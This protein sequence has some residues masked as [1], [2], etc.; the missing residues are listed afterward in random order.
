MCDLKF[1]RQSKRVIAVFSAAALAVASVPG[2]AKAGKT[3]TA[4]EIQLTAPYTT[5][6]K[7]VSSTLTLKKGQS[8]K[9]KATVFPSKA[10]KSTKLTYKSSKKKIASVNKKGRILA[11]KPG[12]ATITI[13][14]K[15]NNKIKATIQVTVIK[16]VKKV[17]KISLNKTT[18]S[19]NLRSGK[20]SE[21]L[22]AKVISPKNATVKKFNWYSTDQS[23]ASVNSKGVVTAKKV[24]TTKIFATS[25]DGRGAKAS[26]LVS[27]YD[28]AVDT[29]PTPNSSNRPSAPPSVTASAAPS[30]TPT[31]PTP[32]PS[33]DPSNSPSS[34]PS[35][36]LSIVIPGNNRT[37]IKQGEKLALTTAGTYEGDISWSVTERAGVSI[38]A[39]GLLSIASDATIGAKITVTAVAAT[40]NSINDTAS[41]T[42]VENQTPVL[43]DKQTQLNESTETNPFG[44]TYRSPDAYSTVSD[45]ERGDVI[46]FDSSQGYT[47]SS[48]DVLAWM[49]VDPKYAG[50]TVKISAYLKYESNPDI[51][52]KLN[53]V[54]N[55]RW[56]YS[57]PAV[58]WNAEP[59]T[60]YYITGTYTFPANTSGKYN[61]SNNRLYICRDSDLTGNINAVYYIDDL[62]FY[63]DKPA[64]SGVTVNAQGNAKI[65]YQNSTLQFTSK[66][67]GAG[68]PPQG[69]T[70]SIDPAVEGASISESGLLSVGDVDADTTIT[71][72][73][74]SVENPDVSGTATVTVAA[75][76]IDS[77][78]ISAAGNVTDIYQ[79]STLQLRANVSSTG[80]PNTSVTWSIEPTVEGASI[81]S[82]GLLTVG[83]V[84]ADTQIHV[85]A[86]SVYDQSKSAEYT[87]TVQASTVDNVTITSAGNKTTVSSGLPLQLSAKVEVTG[88]PSKDVTWSIPSPVEG[89]SLASETGDTN[90]LTVTDSV[91]AETTIT[92]R[93]TSD[94]DSGKYGEITVTVTKDTEEEFNINKL[95]VEYFEDFDGAGTTLD[96][97]KEGDVFSWKATDTSGLMSGNLTK[98]DK[99]YGL[100][101]AE[102]GSP[103]YAFSSIFGSEEDYVQFKINNTDTS[104]KT[105]TLSFMFRFHDID[106]DTKYISTQM[107]TNP[108]FISYKLPLKLVSVDDAENPTTIKENIEI[109]F[110]CSRYSDGNME[111]YDIS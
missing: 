77:I 46:R 41:F 53:L 28:K 13:K 10:K 83:N 14:A 2:Q 61:G 26:C 89:A 57:N 48:Y 87:L 1:L 107:K 66:V 65:I 81:N 29:T 51:K 20:T 60:W 110:R 12:K 62:M 108:S 17:K 25:A 43:T 76:T 45:P 37:G 85:K 100:L 21:Q 96:S 92:V 27:V 18:L 78:S 106:A 35:A 94:Y 15:K 19:I 33:A 22:T 102:G 36:P 16:S 93:A 95:D 11:R 47:S 79:N 34:N 67:E 6:A 56:G 63:V 5:K 55:E 42:I 40:D 54:I 64:V 59:D 31:Q 30:N 111:Y 68:N 101:D 52:K 8:F 104:E 70:Y 84:T 73:A 71:V 49:D 109:P 44:L 103:T 39:D 90:T 7:K 74:T 24:G 9:I 72:K 88:T 3:T 4:K 69:V 32:S 98:L 50:K 80:N 58:K 99:G 91:A 38:S 75:R 82:T 105:Y 23:V 97:I 86:T